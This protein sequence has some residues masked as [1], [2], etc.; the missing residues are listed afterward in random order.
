MRDGL[1]ENHLRPET[2]SAGKSWQCQRNAVGLAYGPASQL[3]RLTHRRHFF[4]AKERSES[5]NA[6]K[7]GVAK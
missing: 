4:V 3:V 5:S 2:S 1:A 6:H 7:H